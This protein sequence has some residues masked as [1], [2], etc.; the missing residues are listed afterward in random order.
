MLPEDSNLSSIMPLHAVVSSAKAKAEERRKRYD[1][2][3]RFASMNDEGAMDNGSI[4]KMIAENCPSECSLLSSPD[5]GHAKSSKQ[6]AIFPTAEWGMSSPLFITGDTEADHCVEFECSM[7]PLSILKHNPK[8]SAVSLAD[9]L[10]SRTL[11]PAHQSILNFL[12]Y[13]FLVF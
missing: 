7:Q 13:F 11:P 3:G 8:V 1:T 2:E 5:C 10:I 12:S 4:P 6:V 9:W